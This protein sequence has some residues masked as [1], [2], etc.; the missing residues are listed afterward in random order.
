MDRWSVGYWSYQDDE[1]NNCPPAGT[2]NWYWVQ[3]DL[4]EFI[5]GMVIWSDNSDKPVV[6]EW[7]GLK[8][9]K[10]GE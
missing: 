3:L 6:A 7:T 8:F 4:P 2:G 5:D 1:G 10:R 9:G